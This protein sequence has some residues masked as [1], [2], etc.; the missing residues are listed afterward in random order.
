MIRVGITGGIGSG[1]S[2]VAHLYEIMGYPVYYADI[3]AK[4]LMNNDP[5]IKTELIATFGKEVY[6][7]HLDRKV[8]AAIVFSNPDA[9]AKL[10]SITHPAVK[11][12]MDEWAK[13]QDS[14]II[15]KEAAIL[16]ESGTNR[17][18]D[19]TICVIAPEITRVM[20]VMKRDGVTASQVQERIKNQWSDDKKIALS[21]FVLYADEQQLV[22]SQALEI[23]KHLEKQIPILR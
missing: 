15:F 3:R 20:R 12:D 14:P 16:F 21:D 6:P 10:N 13:R 2:T 18:V 4:W 11:R 19:K 8:L 7:Q 17:S 22:I 1:K 23:L 5:I 9:L